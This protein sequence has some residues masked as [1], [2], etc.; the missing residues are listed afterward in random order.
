LGSL[1]E[2]KHAQ[3]KH[4]YPSPANPTES[5]RMCQTHRQVTS[6]AIRAIAKYHKLPGNSRSDAVE[7]ILQER[8]GS[9]L[10]CLFPGVC[11][12]GT[13][14]SRP[15]QHKLQQHKKDL[16]DNSYEVMALNKEFA[17]MESLLFLRMYWKKGE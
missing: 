16:V 4:R 17:T 12:Q 10:R 7:T 1:A 13:A 3:K 5:A 15:Q 14:E 6:R 2:R 9:H 11:A 8:F